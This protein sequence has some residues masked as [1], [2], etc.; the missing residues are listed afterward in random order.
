MG[1]DFL[2]YAVEELQLANCV[3][4]LL[5]TQNQT[6]DMVDRYVSP[7]IHQSSAF[8]LVPKCIQDTL[9]TRD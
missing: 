2:A 8:L 7:A 6:P 5:I 3:V 1:T 4:K 9:P